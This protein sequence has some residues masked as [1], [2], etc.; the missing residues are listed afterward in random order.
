[1]NAFDASS[2]A[3]FNAFLEDNFDE[4]TIERGR[5]YWRTKRVLAVEL[6]V[7]GKNSIRVSGLVEGSED[8]PYEQVIRVA[9]G[10][11]DVTGHCTC[12]V[13]I[14][15]KHVVAALLRGN[16]EQPFAFAHGGPRIV[17]QTAKRAMPNLNSGM[18]GMEDKAVAKTV[19]E[20]P[21]PYQVEAWLLGLSQ[22]LRGEA[23]EFPADVTQ[24]LLYIF[25]P[26]QS[27]VESTCMIGL[28]QARILKSGALSGVSEYSNT[29]AWTN[30]PRFMSPRDVRI[31]RQLATTQRSSYFLRFDTLHMSAT[32]IEEIVAT[33]RAYWQK[34]TNP[35][36][37]WGAA[38]P[39]KVA[40]STLANG[41]RRAAIVVDPDATVLASEPLCFLDTER[42]L[43]GAA[44]IDL[45]PEVAAAVVA[46]PVLPVA[47][48][49]R[50]NRELQ[51]RNLHHVL[52]PST[53]LTEKT[54]ADYQPVP[55]LSLKSHKRQFYDAHT[56][57]HV[58]SFIDTATLKFD[59][60]G[61]CVTGKSPSEI[62]RVHAKENVLERVFRNSAYERDARATLRQSGLELV[63]KALKSGVSRG[64]QGSM[65]VHDADDDQIATSTW[66]RWMKVEAPRLRA[67]GWQIEID[68]DF[69]FDLV[70]IEGWYADVEESGNHWFDLEIGIDV[71]GTRLS[72]IPILLKAIRSAPDVWRHDVLAKQN[73]DALMIVPLPNNRRVALSMARLKPLLAT[74]FELYMR[75][76]SATRVR[77]ST[78]DAARLA[79]MDHALKL[80]WVGGERLREM[81]E[82]LARFTGLTQVLPPKNFSATLRSYQQAGLNWLQFLREYDLAGVLADDMGLGKTVQTLAHIAVEKA[83]GRLTTPA[84]VVAPTSMMSTWKSEAERFSPNLKV[85]VSHG[86]ARHVG[87]EKFAAYDL[88]LTTYALLARDEAALKKQ[89]W[90]L[91]ILDEAQN[92]KNPKTKAA[93]IASVLKTQHRLCLSGT[94]LENH[95]GELWSLFN[96]LLPGFLG[97][98]KTF[99][100]EFRKP[101]EK[102]N[103]IGRRQ[104]LARR[105]KPFLLR[106]TKDMVA[107]ELPAKTIITRMVEF[108][109]AQADLYETVRAAMDQRVQEEI[110]SKG[111]ARSHIVVLD[112]LLKLRQICC[113]PRLF[114]A[115]A[116]QK[117]P[118]SAKLGA[119]M[120]MLTELIAE[121]R[122][123]L[124]FS[125][126][127]SMLALIEAELDQQKIAYVKLTGATK[128][129]KSPVDQFQSGAVKIFLISL[130][131]GGT[132]LTLTAADTVIH[133]DPWWNPAAENQATDRA[134]RIG[135][136]KPVFVYKFVM[137]GSVEERIV[138][139]QTR[140]GVLA[141][142][143]LDGDGEAISAMDGD[144]LKTLFAPM[145][146]T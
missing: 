47:L 103:D 39:A 115:V 24:R 34:H 126:F 86:S 51:Q 77:L 28:R 45:K 89:A 61:E 14:N 73:D 41:D 140:K 44:T 116:S 130:K 58:T 8:Q 7:L 32:L 56:W 21:L 79:E 65:V 27:A 93:M 49:E 71:E 81:G 23:D 76:P 50:V 92:I 108:D 46:S 37:T 142:G 113:D 20:P 101:I 78:L 143:L 13:S 107:S 85:W 69:R 95:L 104:Y 25:E 139:M 111:L 48:V 70:N 114:K 137:K 125:Q 145:V 60:L 11:G 124:L 88:V 109:A 90:Y 132:G 91:V 22:A 75:E 87:V 128:D 118:P 10:Q 36:L 55:V 144:V 119:L 129:R 123:I 33:G 3:P 64:L 112:A 133:Y 97:D 19:V 121:G 17:P 43:V 63:E 94:P 127:T 110:A 18:A 131:A 57:K 105:I 26:P 5:Q 1:M 134:H 117:S 106:R 53:V 35:V 9:L 83:A 141:A 31:L 74:L 136:T 98:E 135:Q 100:R 59:Y 6:D 12:P 62:T 138:E 52:A 54:L 80:R 99:T 30:P 82:K 120:E 42:A 72:L 66:M 68:K 67:A 40:W 16:E 38:R 84:L 29:H 146:E 2:D 122:S 102:E 96:F 15:C 4:K